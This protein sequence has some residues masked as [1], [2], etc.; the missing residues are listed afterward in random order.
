MKNS[1]MFIAMKR[2][3]IV[4]GHEKVFKEL[5][6]KRETHLNGVKGFQSFNLIKGQRAEYY[7]LYA[8]HTVRHSKNYF[9]KWTKSSA[10]RKAHKSSGENNNLYLAHPIF[11]GFAVIL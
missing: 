3:K 1:L 8:S 7:T 2:L 5:R 9:E 11:E 6:R 10:F 4:P